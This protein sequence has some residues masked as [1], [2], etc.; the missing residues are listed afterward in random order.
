M[1]EIIKE[2]LLA[3]NQRIIDMV[4]ERIKRDYPEDIAIVGLSGSFSSNDF[5]EKSDLDLIIINNTDKGWEIMT[6]FILDDIGYDIYCTPWE[7]CIE[8]QANLESFAVGCLLDMEILYCGD[9]LYM[10]KLTSLRKRAL[11]VLAEPIGEPCLLRAETTLQEAKA[12]YTDMMITDDLGAVRYASKS[13]LTDILHSI[14]HM[15][16]TYIKKGIISYIE[17]LASYEYLPDDFEKMY[18]AVIKASSVESIRQKSL[19]LLSKVINYHKEMMETLVTKP[20]PSYENLKGTYEELWCNCRN[21]VLRAASIEDSNYA[22]HV[23]GSAQEFLDEMHQSKGTKKYDLMSFFNGADMTAFKNHFIEVMV[24]YRKE[25]DRV[26]RPVKEYD[27]LD[28]LYNDFM[29]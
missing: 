2:L 25:Y 9:E 19:D 29:A 21:K 28:D 17:E 4:I 24:D 8:A 6:C 12:A 7:T 22:I 20:K 14:V 5:H 26:G 27:S 10:K 23:A 13:I 18:L 1:N 16:N 11:D 15:N 3:K